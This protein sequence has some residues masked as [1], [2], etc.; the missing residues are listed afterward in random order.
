MKAAGVEVEPY[1]PSLFSKLL[2]KV[3][4]GDL[5]KGMTAAPVVAAAPV[6]GAPAAAAA[7]AGGGDAP[8]AAGEAAKEEEEEDDDMGLDMFGGEDDY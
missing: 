6:A 1:W 5:I 8:A 4:V 2:E 3:T 7:A